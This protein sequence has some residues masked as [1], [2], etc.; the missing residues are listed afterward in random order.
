MRYNR[1]TGWRFLMAASTSFRISESARR[2]LATRA[3]Q[4]GISATALVERLIIEGVEQ[5]DFPGVVFRGPAHD[6]R[7]AL[8]AGPDVWEVIARLRELEGSTEERI[9]TLSEESELHPRLLRLA[10]DYAAEHP[11][12]IRRRMDRNDEMVERSRAAA[13]QRE[14]L[15]A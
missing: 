11:D 9:A 3:A 15:L 1:G 2:R 14:A 7:A 13:Q 5:L 12:E 8:A 4:D 10:V 6:R